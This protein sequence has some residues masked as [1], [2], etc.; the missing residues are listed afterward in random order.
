MKEWEKLIKRYFEFSHSR[1]PH[2]EDLDKKSGKFKIGTF[3]HYLPPFFLYTLVVPTLT[4][5]ELEKK[6]CVSV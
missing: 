4:A 6:I 2:L 3:F 1:V 5:L